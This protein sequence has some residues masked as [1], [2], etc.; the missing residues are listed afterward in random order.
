MDKLQEYLN[1]RDELLRSPTLEGAK[2]WFSPDG[3][4]KFSK[5]DIPLAA[6]HKARLQ[7]IHATDEMLAESIKWLQD[8]GYHTSFAGAD[9]LTPEERD[10]QRIMHGLEP[11]NK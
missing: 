1:A 4:S 11:L 3:E 9:P 5:P 10:R 6:V 2:K 8:N 7:W